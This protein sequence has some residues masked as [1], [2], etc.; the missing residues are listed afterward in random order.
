M[1]STEKDVLRTDIEKLGQ[2]LDVDF[3]GVASQ[4]RFKNAP[5][6]HK[7]QDLLPDIQSVIS[8]GLRIPDGVSEANHRA[9]EMDGFDSRPS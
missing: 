1:N 7:S 8:V 6:F 2:K 5:K 3:V 4:N 9:F